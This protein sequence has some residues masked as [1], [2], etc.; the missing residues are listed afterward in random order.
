MRCRFRAPTH[1]PHQ[2]C[3]GA[4]PAT[5]STAPEGLWPDKAGVQTSIKKEDWPWEG[6]GMKVALSSHQG[7][8]SQLTN[9]DPALQ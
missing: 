5:S 9:K 2:Q 3:H 6:E 4:V 1:F 7:P 8:S